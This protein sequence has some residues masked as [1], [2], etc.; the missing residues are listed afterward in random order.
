MKKI[1]FYITVSVLFLPF[2][3]CLILIL[4]SFD[5][6]AGFHAFAGC[7]LIAGIMLIETKYALQPAKKHSPV[8]TV[9]EMFHQMKKPNMYKNLCIV[10]FLVFL[11][12]GIFN[13]VNGLVS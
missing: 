4:L 5:L 3:I 10:M 2:V 12:I 7:F 8:N 9:K 11:F 1:L 6:S 13:L